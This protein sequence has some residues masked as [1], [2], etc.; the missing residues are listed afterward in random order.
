MRKLILLFTLLIVALSYSQS[1]DISTGYRSTGLTTTQLNALPAGQKTSGLIIRDI[2]K[3]S[4]VSWNGSAYIPILRGGGTGD[5]LKSENLSGLANNATALTNLG[6]TAT[7]AELNYTDGVTS[8]IQTQLN[9]TVK[10]TGNQ[11]I[12]GTKTFDG[13]ITFFDAGVRIVEGNTIQIVNTST[14]A[15]GNLVMSESGFYN[16]KATSDYSI[17]QLR[18]N[19]L[20]EL[21]YDGFF[22]LSYYDA[23]ILKTDASG[24]VTS[25]TVSTTELADASVT[26]AKILDSTILPADL[27]ESA[28]NLANADQVITTTKKITINSGQQLLIEE[29]DGTPLARFY[30][31]GANPYFE[32]GI[33][34][35]E[36]PTN[37]NDAASKGY[38]DAAA[39]IGAGEI[40]TTEIQDGTIVNA[41]VSASAAIVVSKLAPGANGEVLTTTGGAVAWGVPTDYDT[42]INDLE[43]TVVAF[44]EEQEDQNDR[45]TALE[46]PLLTT[47]QIVADYTTVAADNKRWIYGNSSTDITTTINDTLYAPNT[48][49]IFNQIA[50][51]KVK[52]NF[53]NE[54]KTWATAESKPLYYYQTDS[55]FQ[56]LTMIKGIDSVWRP[57][58][59]Q[60]TAWTPYY[61]LLEEYQP[62]SYW[63]FTRITEADAAAVPTLPDRG[64]GG[65]SL[66][67]FNGPVVQSSGGVKEGKFDGTNDYMSAGNPANL[68]LLP[69]EEWWIVYVSGSSDG[70][71]DQFILNKGTNA[72]S[73]TASQFGFRRTGGTLQGQAAGVTGGSTAG[74]SGVDVYILNCNGTSTFF[75]KN[76]TLIS[77][78]TNGAFTSANNIIVGARNN[79]GDKFFSGSVR[80][81]ALKKGES[82]TAGQISALNVFNP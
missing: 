17:G 74:Y 20:G 59:K 2:T 25:N 19:Q 80:R 51:G 29:Q 34:V 6:L 61:D 14:P 49:L 30:N 50:A 7:A 41:D 47:T 60:L 54:Y 23:G 39:T 73:T 79:G 55:I 64:S 28:K 12:S 10:T 22:K 62:T 26:T 38:V 72:S 35:S 56:S 46:S 77:T 1:L 68:D 69:N 31:T 36:T 32:Q 42:Q 5:M 24:N 44:T 33:R 67:P 37:S 82:L 57:V 53:S 48:T 21:D 78:I 63:D 75:Y 76:G 66:T 65:N 58:G 70:A 8:A 43:N 45:L 4:L 16:T 40:T 15:L 13:A 11:T 81:I 9:G 3:D 18:F 27:S 71:G 52:V